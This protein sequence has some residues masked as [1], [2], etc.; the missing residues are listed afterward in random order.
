MRVRPSDVGDAKREC[1][2]ALFAVGAQLPS[3]PPKVFAVFAQL[4]SVCL[5]FRAGCFDTLIVTGGGRRAQVLAVAAEFATIL[6]EFGLV[7]TDLFAIFT[8]ILPVG[9]QFLLVDFVRQSRGRGNQ[10]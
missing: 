6:S 4:L 5:Q 9:P 7:A 2:A 10:H 8:Q 1:L 3:I